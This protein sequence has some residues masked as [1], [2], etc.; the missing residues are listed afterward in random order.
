MATIADVFGVTEDLHLL[1]YAWTLDRL[2]PAAGEPSRTLD[3]D[4]LRRHLRNAPEARVELGE[5]AYL[6]I[7]STRH[8]EV[9]LLLLAA[10]YD[11]QRV[12]VLPAAHRRSLPP[13]VPDVPTLVHLYGDTLA[14]AS[15]LI[16][17]CLLARGLDGNEDAIDVTNLAPALAAPG[18]YEQLARKLDAIDADTARPTV[19]FASAT[20]ADAR[21]FAEL[22]PLLR[23]Q[24]RELLAAAGRSTTDSD[25]ERVTRQVVAG[26]KWPVLRL[27]VRAAAAAGC[28][29]RTPRSQPSFRPCTTASTTVGAMRSRRRRRSSSGRRLPPTHSTRWRRSTSDARPDGRPGPVA[30][31]VDRSTPSRPFRSGDA[32]STLPALISRA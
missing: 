31:D 4:E 12:V 3:L 29:H 11:D 25:V 5:H 17:R 9:A 21:R 10:R 23:A 7:E 14:D 27:L 19:A 32:F 22:L 26:K 13:A 24:L 1:V 6:V 16:G 8:I 2:T 30:T 15:T 18:T 28:R 20:A